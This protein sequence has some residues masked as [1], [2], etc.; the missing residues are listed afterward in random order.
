MLGDFSI[1]RRLT[2]TERMMNDAADFSTFVIV[3]LLTPRDGLF[4]APRMVSRQ[5]KYLWY[6]PKVLEQTSNVWTCLE[7][8]SAHTPDAVCLAFVCVHL[9]LL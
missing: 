3:I 8:A 7:V 6:V 1:N 5:A 9:S 2:N 4:S